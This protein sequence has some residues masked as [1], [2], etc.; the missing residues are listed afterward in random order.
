MQP[1]AAAIVAL[2]TRYRETS[3]HMQI[4]KL[5]VL[6]S[7]ADGMLLFPCKFFSLVIS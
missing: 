4:Y 5:D 2:G 1:A 3:L 6:D 7:R